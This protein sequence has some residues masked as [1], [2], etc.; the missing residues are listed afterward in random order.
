MGLGPPVIGLFHLLRDRG[1]FGKTETVAD[2]G[3]QEYDSKLD[4]YD[5]AYRSFVRAA[6]GTLPETTDPETG[7]LKGP[8]ASLYRA[9]GWEY[10]SFDIDGRFGACVADFN[11][12]EIPASHHGKYSI[13]MNL[14]TS[15]HVFNQFQFFKLQH[16]AT[17]VGG[18]MIHTLPLND[19][20]NHGLYSYSPTFFHSLA[21]YNRY[22][23]LGMWKTGKENLHQFLPAV[24]PFEERRMFVF[25]VLR[26]TVDQPFKIP[27][28]VNEPM[29]LSSEAEARYTAHVPLD[30]GE[31]S[32][33]QSLPREFWFDVKNY[34]ISLEPVAVE[35]TRDQRRLAKIESLKKDLAKTRAASSNL[36]PPPKKQRGI[37]SLFR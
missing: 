14:G 3:S 36:P 9:L 33:S 29:V 11:C 34:R 24:E 8:A 17:K 18:I 19:Y 27:L 4:T 20:V 15:E 22:E 25:C 6:G 35:L 37:L 2:F 28:Q 21:K 32:K 16:L 13:T 31:L 10:A 23:L 12:D 1:V 7:R 5:E 26:K 30:L